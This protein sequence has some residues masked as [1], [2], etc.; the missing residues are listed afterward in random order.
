[1]PVADTELLFALGETDPKHA[2]A[3]QLMRR[4]KGIVAPDTSIL[5]F[6][7]VL[8]SRG[9]SAEQVRLALLALTKVFLDNDIAEHRT[10]DMKLLILQS[11]IEYKYGLSYFD[12]LI[13]ASAFTIDG[14]VVSDDEDF[15]GVPDLKRISVSE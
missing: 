5:E 15:D 4:V 13:A 10:M 9:R 3:L 14:E 7:T 1:M 6:Q 11:E 8:R 2:K 12:S